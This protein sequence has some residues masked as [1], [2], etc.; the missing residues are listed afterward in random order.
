MRFLSVAVSKCLSMIG[1]ENWSVRAVGVVDL[2][3]G[4]DSS[5]SFACFVLSFRLSDFS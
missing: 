1:V 5:F 4:T 2:K 3:F